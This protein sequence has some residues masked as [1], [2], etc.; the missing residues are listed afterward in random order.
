MNWVGGNGRRGESVSTGADLGGKPGGAA[1]LTF[2]HE[3]PRRTPIDQDPPP[4]PPEAPAPE[5]AA[6][7]A[8]A[9]VYDLYNEAM[10]RYRDELKA[11]KARHPGAW[12]V[13]PRRLAGAS[14]RQHSLIGPRGSGASWRKTAGG[15]QPASFMWMMGKGWPASS[16]SERPT[17]TKP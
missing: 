10:D 1:P 13:V 11:W 14:A 2:R 9:C 16:C 7:T 17:S 15:F 6:T 12:R 3:H 4:V 8:H 5:N